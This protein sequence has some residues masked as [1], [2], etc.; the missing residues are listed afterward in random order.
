M[1]LGRFAEKSKAVGLS[2]NKFGLWASGDI[3]PKFAS[4]LISEASI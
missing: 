4:L 1:Y 2:P 3:F